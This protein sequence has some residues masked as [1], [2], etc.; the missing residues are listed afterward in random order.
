MQIFFSDIVN[1]T[2]ISETLTAEQLLT[3][4]GYVGLHPM[5]AQRC[6]A[7]FVF[8]FWFHWL[9]IFPI[10]QNWATLHT[11][12]ITALLFFAVFGPVGSF[13]TYITIE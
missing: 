1:F 11:R 9:K 4:I 13:A 10:S 7:C 8:V 12:M 2:S 5:V 6:I 3:V